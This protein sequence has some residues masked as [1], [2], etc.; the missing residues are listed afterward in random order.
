MAS[1]GYD[2][3]TW[4][5]LDIRHAARHPDALYAMTLQGTHQP[6]PFA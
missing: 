6:R 3:Q 1:A 2:A 5:A 4:F